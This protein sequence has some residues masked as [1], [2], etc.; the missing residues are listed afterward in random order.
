MNQLIFSPFTIAEAAGE[1]RSIMDSSTAPF[2]VVVHRGRGRPPGSG[3]RNQPA[4]VPG[5]ESMYGKGTSKS[6]LSSHIYD[7]KRSLKSSRNSS[8][9]ALDSAAL[10]GLPFKPEPTV[11]SSANVHTL[12]QQITERPLTDGDLELLNAF[13]FWA[14]QPAIESAMKSLMVQRDALVNK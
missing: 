13:R 8:N 11:C 1:K 5:F 2:N 6:L 12:I 10:Y 4:V 3:R 14:P 9:A 7:S